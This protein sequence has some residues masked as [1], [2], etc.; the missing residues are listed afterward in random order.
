M[1]SQ[2]FHSTIVSVKKGK[3][4]FLHPWQR[5]NAEKITATFDCSLFCA[6]TALNHSVFRVQTI[7][8]NV[9]VQTLNNLFRK[10]GLQEGREAELSKTSPF[11][12]KEDVLFFSNTFFLVCE[13]CWREHDFISSHLSMPTLLFNFLVS[14][15]YSNNSLWQWFCQPAL[16]PFSKLL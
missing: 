16:H 2:P 10:P 5:K 15:P 9:T 3:W 13:T 1:S 11:G 8:Q 6:W 7:F 14:C 12:K 4:L